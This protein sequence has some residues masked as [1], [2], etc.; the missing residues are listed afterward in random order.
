MI[1]NWAKWRVFVCEWTEK[2]RRLVESVL[3]SPAF[4]PSIRSSSVTSPLL[5]PPPFPP[6]CRWCVGWRD[7]PRA[8]TQLTHAD[9]HLR[10]VSL[11]IPPA[12]SR[13]SPLAAPTAHTCCTSLPQ[14]LTLIHSFHLFC[15]ESFLSLPRALHHPHHHHHHHDHTLYTRHVSPPRRRKK[16]APVDKCKR[17]RGRRQKSV[18]RVWSPATPPSA[19]S[20]SLL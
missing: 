14:F 12:S 7:G 17:R 8:L 20:R 2:R 3:P 13:H 9:T 1:M 10:D 4:H 6:P 5:P 11:P 15:P 19:S 16:H 18:E